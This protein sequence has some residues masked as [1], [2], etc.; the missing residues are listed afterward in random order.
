MESYGLAVAKASINAMSDD[1]LRSM[2]ESAIMASEARI[3]SMQQIIHD[4]TNIR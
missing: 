3:R 1:Q 4:N 2:S